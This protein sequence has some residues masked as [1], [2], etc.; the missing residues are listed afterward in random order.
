METKGYGLT[1]LIKDTTFP[2]VPPFIRPMWRHGKAQPQAPTAQKVCSLTLF[3]PGEKGQKPAQNEIA[4][5]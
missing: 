2:A 1:L 4:A 5:K 3:Q